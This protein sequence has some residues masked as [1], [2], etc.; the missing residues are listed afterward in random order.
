MAGLQSA[1]SPPK[2]L[3][4]YWALLMPGIGPTQL[5]EFIFGLRTIDGGIWVKIEEWIVSNQGSASTDRIPTRRVSRCSQTGVHSRTVLALRPAG[6]YRSPLRAHR[7]GRRVNGRD[8]IEWSAPIWVEWF[9]FYAIGM[10]LL[11]VFAHYKIQILIDFL[12]GIVWFWFC[13]VSL[14]RNFYWW[15]F[16]WFH[17]YLFFVWC[18]TISLL[19]G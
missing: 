1:G 14:T 9:N 7:T 15:I 6:C 5:I 10:E 11:H 3:S 16:M 12:S 19:L 17:V 8:Q 18:F 13:L 2:L 4:G